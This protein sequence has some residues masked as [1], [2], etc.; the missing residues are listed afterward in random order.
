MQASG[1]DASN[2]MPN[3]LLHMHQLHTK[4]VKPDNSRVGGWSYLGTVAVPARAP[5]DIMS[6]VYIYIYIDRERER[7]RERDVVDID[8][9]CVIYIYNL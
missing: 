1:K 4:S 8:K 2:R 7:E 9:T 6:Y 5:L 3:L